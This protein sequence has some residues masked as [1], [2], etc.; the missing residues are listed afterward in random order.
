MKDNYGRRLKG[1]ESLK[2]QQLVKKDL[3]FEIPKTKKNNYI[4]NN[5]NIEISIIKILKDL[6]HLMIKVYQ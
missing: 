2:T 3:L 1:Y 4:L 5:I 6:N